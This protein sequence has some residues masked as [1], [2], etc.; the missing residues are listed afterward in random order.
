MQNTSEIK[1][2][3]VTSYKGS[4]AT[5]TLC[6]NE[7]ILR[8]GKAEL[9]RMSCEHNLRTF[10]SWLKAGFRVRKN[11]KAIKSYTFLQETKDGSLVLRKYYRRPVYLFYFLQVEPLNQSKSL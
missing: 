1:N 5:K 11:E 8:Y 3:P 2:L 7:I 9:K 4:E 6:E 10:N